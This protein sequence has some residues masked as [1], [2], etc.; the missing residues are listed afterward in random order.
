MVVGKQTGQPCG[1]KEREGSTALELF[2]FFW[3]TVMLSH[4]IF[5]FLCGVFFSLLFAVFMR[6]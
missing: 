4:C 5:F 1:E 3:C 2:F 6:V